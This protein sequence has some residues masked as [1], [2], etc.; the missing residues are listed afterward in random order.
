MKNR[1]LACAAILALGFGLS[2]CEP[3]GNAGNVY[4]DAPAS[5]P[6]D[7]YENVSPDQIRY[8]II[9]DMA[10]QG[11]Y[12]S[13][14][15]N[16][17]L[18][19]R[20]FGNGTIERVSFYLVPAYNGTR[21]IVDQNYYN[22]YQG[23]YSLSLEY[24]RV[25]RERRMRERLDRFRHDYYG[26]Y[27]S[28]PNW[29]RDRDHDNRRDDHNDRDRHD[30]RDNGNNNRNNNDR[31]DDNNR[32][33]NDRRDNDRRD[34]DRSG[35]W[36]RHPGQPYNPGQVR[37]DHQQNQEQGPNGAIL[38]RPGND[39][40]NLT[41]EQRQRF[42]QFQQQRQQWERQNQEQNRQI[43]QQRFQQQNQQRQQQEQIRQ[44]RQRPPQQPPS[45]ADDNQQSRPSQQQNDEIRARFRHQPPQ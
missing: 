1:Y 31:R 42:E 7:F 32:P 40:Q 19:E 38:N 27:Q 23:S 35:D 4:Y 16:P 30:W 43:Q 41:P 21:V 33:D 28:N 6:G 18:F 25:I 34:N 22:Y 37:P 3:V 5:N 14:Q 8:A 2:A 44:Q 45:N 13:G 24:D 36:Q 11:F 39:R 12:F 26:H 15:S 10:A 17:L 20:R 29:R 9:N